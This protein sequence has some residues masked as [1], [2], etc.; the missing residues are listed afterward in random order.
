VRKWL[1]DGFGE[2]DGSVRVR[3]DADPQACKEALARLCRH[4]NSGEISAARDE[5]VEV[6][7]VFEVVPR[8]AQP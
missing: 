6:D 7:S 8:D 1:G 5:G 3:A 4:L 2:Q